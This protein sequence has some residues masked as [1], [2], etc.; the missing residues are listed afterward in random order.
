MV[1]LKQDKSNTRAT[2]TFPKDKKDNHIEII[3]TYEDEERT[4]T[5][6]VKIHTDYA[7][8]FVKELHETVFLKEMNDIL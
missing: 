1:I 5:A 8:Q 4:K 3:F 7:R 6:N 2:M